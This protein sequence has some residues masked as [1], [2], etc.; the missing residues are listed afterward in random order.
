MHWPEVVSIA[1]WAAGWLLLRR[2]PL[3]PDSSAATLDDVSLIVPAR[4]EAVNIAGLLQSIGASAVRPNEVLVADDDSADDTA[5][6][7]SA[8]GARVLQ[9]HGPPDAWTGK[10][11]ACHCA[12]FEAHGT[13]LFFADAD[14]RFAREGYPRLT[15]HFAGLQEDAALS[16][17]PY[18]LAEEWYEELSL[19]FLLL[20]AMGAGGFA[21][22]DEPKLFGQSLLIPAA[23]YRRCGGHERVRLEILENLNLAQ[24]VRAAGAR[25]VARGGRGV[26]E[27]RMFP[28]GYAQMCESF[29]K[30]FASGAGASSKRVL[31]LSIVWLTGAMTAFLRLAAVGV[32]S[33]AAERLIVCAVYLLLVAQIAWFARQLGSFRLL[34]A[35]LYPAPLV[36]YFGLFAQSAWRRAMHKPVT[37]RGRSL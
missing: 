18:Q 25:N 13:T 11:W 28:H 21:G 1:G 15:G 30:A 26:L 27:S 34:T 2:V 23:L 35:L 14:V 20:M 12:S 8:L 6:I 22:L 32:V 4:N 5:A 10:N 37:W 36:F 9:L 29:R 31:A 7:A 33:S 3:V 24:H 19:F 17:L 16:V